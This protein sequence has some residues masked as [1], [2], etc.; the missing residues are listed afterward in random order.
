MAKSLLTGN[1]IAGE[2]AAEG[3]AEMEPPAEFAIE[4]NG[5]AT[6]AAATVPNPASTSRRLII[7]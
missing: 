4:P 5:P 6:P 1:E 3:T 2:S 7:V